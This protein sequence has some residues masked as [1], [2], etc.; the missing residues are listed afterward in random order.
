LYARKP[1]PH[2]YSADHKERELAEH[3][4]VENALVMRNFSAILGAMLAII[5]S[6][7]SA[8]RAYK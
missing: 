3:D 5:V 6:V 1:V 4:L 8:T 7:Y 2:V